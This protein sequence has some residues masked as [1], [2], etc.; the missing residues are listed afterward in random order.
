MGHSSLFGRIELTMKKFLSVIQRLNKQ[1]TAIGRWLSRY[2]IEQAN[3][4]ELLALIAARSKLVNESLA[5]QQ[6]LTDILRGEGQPGVREDRLP[7]LQ[8]QL[9]TSLAEIE[10]QDNLNRQQIAEFQARILQKSSGIK[11]GKKA[12]SAYNVFPHQKSIFVDLASS[13]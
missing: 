4:G 8:N 10:K 7:G 2:E 6:Q 5:R 9:T 13:N 11:Q 1:T 3:I 12:V